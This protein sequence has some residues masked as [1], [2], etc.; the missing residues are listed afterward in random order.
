MNLAGVEVILDLKSR[1]TRMEG[2]VGRLMESI[3][4]VAA[5]HASRG[6]EARRRS[7][8][9][10]AALVVRPRGDRCVLATR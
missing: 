5:E 10:P 9:T 4:A 2:E 7:R 3:R 1:L 6:R 8:E